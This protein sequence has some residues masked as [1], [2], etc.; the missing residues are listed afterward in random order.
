MLWVKDGDEVKPGDRLTEGS[1]DLK[2]LFHLRGRL[3][4]QKYIIKEIQYVY[5]SQ[6][7][8]L[9]INILRLLLVKCFLVI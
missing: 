3:E 4:T 5:S 9:M 8:H 2:E 1:F 7:Q 6:G